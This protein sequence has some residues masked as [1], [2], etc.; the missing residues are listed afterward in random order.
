M[1]SNDGSNAAALGD[2]WPEMSSEEGL[3]AEPATIVDDLAGLSSFVL[4]T[5]L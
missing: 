5:R 3:I 4:S 2:E 1:A